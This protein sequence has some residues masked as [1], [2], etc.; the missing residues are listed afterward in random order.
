MGLESFSRGKKSFKID[1]PSEHV[2]DKQTILENLQK[3]KSDS[4][5]MWLDHAV[6]LF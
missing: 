5:V 3:H 4:Y 1:Y 6:L 2:M